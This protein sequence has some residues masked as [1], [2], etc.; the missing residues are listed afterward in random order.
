MKTMT[1][2]ELLDGVEALSF[3]RQEALVEIVRMRLHERRREEIRRNAE[4]ARADFEAG[5]LPCGSVEDLMLDLDSEE[6]RD[7][8]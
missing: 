1:F 8:A 5:R 6:G 2:D 7:D 3:E 4:M